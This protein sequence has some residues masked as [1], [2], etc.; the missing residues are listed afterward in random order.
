PRGPGAAT[1]V[2]ARQPPAAPQRTTGEI[3]GKVSDASGGVLP[4]VTVTL[5]GPAL[6]GEQVD[7]TTASGQYRF[8]VV[9]A[10]TYELEY[11]LSGFTGVKVTGIFVVVGATVQLDQSLKARALHH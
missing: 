1:R 9:P 2:A 4:G 8:P 7:V 3:V 6:Q 10:G 5:R 11:A